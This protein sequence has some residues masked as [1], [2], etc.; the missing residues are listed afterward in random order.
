[1][2][3]VFH[4][5]NGDH[6]T[7]VLKKLPVK[8]NIITWS[9]ML[10]EGKT[11]TNIGSTLFWKTRYGFFKHTYK[12]TKNLYLPILREYKNLCDQRTQEE[13]VLWFDDNLSG[14]INMIAMI[15]WLRNH[16]KN[17]QVSLV[18]G[19][20]NNAGMRTLNDLSEAELLQHYE[21]RLH[22][23]EDD[24][25]YADYVWQ[26]YCSDNPLRL[27]TFA[28]FNA[29]QFQ[30]L[31]DA[32]KAHILRFP[33]IKTGLNTIENEV[34]RTAFEQKPE[35]REALVEILDTENVY[36]YTDFQYR[37]IIRNLKS[38]FQS[39]N[40]VKLTPTGEALL[41]Q[42]G[43]YYA[44]MRNDDAYLGG[45]RKYSY[46]YNTTTEKLLKL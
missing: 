23:T 26:L 32:I 14:Q 18:S 13:A 15:S 22:L 35:S 29:S 27:E 16:K 3:N 37:K 6:F 4:I 39:F 21:N 11:V 36:G 44:A 20:N 28:K 43:N 17:I 2:D 40:P 34:L 45:S 38:L 24:V 7:S 9:E 31:T 41:Y 46:L 8:G 19:S 1:M 33:T 30:H 5:T 25:N 10:C 12:I 42:T